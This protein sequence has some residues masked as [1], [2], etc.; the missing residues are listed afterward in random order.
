MSVLERLYSKLT[1]PRKA[2]GSPDDEA[3][4][5]F[6]EGALDKDGYGRFSY[7]GRSRPAHRASYIVHKGHIPEGKVVRHTCHCRACCNPRH[8]VLG[9]QSDNIEDRQKAGRQARGARNGRSKLNAQKVREIRRAADRGARQSEMARR[10][11][12][13]PTTVRD[14]VLQKIWKHV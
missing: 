8:L 9:T 13:H 2:D 4:W 7:E 3:C 5:L 14:I 11:A 12:I 6:T 10:Y 1:I